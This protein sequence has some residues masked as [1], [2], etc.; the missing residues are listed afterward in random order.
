MAEQP[1]SIE[2]A[3]HCTSGAAIRVRIGPAIDANPFSLR[4]ALNAQGEIRR[5]RRS[6]RRRLRGEAETE[7]RDRADAAQCGRWLVREKRDFEAHPVGGR[8]AL[9]AGHSNESVLD[10]PRVKPARRVEEGLGIRVRS[11]TTLRRSD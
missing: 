2:E 3:R 1:L 11:S 5:A 9:V 6:P 7:V 4:L 10:T 8:S